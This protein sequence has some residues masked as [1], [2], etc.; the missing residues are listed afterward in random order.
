MQVLYADA[1]E[2]GCSHHSIGRIKAVGRWCGANAAV[3]SDRLTTVKA[4]V[5]VAEGY[6]VDAILGVR[7]EVDSVHIA[8][9]DGTPLKRLTVTSVAVKCDVLLVQ[10]AAPS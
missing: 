3:D 9:L 1:S 7:S 10:W 2:I 6:D 5:E 4:L 8:D